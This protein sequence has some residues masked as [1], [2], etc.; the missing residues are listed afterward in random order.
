MDIVDLGLNQESTIQRTAAVLVTGL[1]RF[2]PYFRR[3]GL[4]AV[5][6]VVH[7]LRE[8]GE[9]YGKSPAQVALRWLIENELVLP[10][11]GA[12]NGKQAADNAG[13]LAFR[14]TAAE[15]EALDRATL[16]WRV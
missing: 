8:I 1:R 14:L 5:E 3:K 2:F 15:I 13:A 11:P 10:I 7:L 6:P 9:R 16:A 4:A 12:K